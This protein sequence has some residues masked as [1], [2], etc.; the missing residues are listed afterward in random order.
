[1]INKNPSEK[2]FQIVT[3]DG[4]Q[5][6]VDSSSF[7][8]FLPQTE[9]STITTSVDRAFEDSSS[10]D[11]DLKSITGK[12]IYTIATADSLSISSKRVKPSP[13]ESSS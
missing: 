1:M 8:T 5:H 12:A 11:Y 13:T 10:S 7:A 4:H 9:W 3:V 2:Y 6:S